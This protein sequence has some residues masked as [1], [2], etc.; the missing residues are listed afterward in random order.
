MEKW[1]EYYWLYGISYK[2]ESITDTDKLTMLS[3]LLVLYRDAC[4]VSYYIFYF[5][6][7]SGQDEKRSV[8]LKPASLLRIWE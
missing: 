7:F 4:L 8:K 6:F 5:S 3:P 2:L 1:K